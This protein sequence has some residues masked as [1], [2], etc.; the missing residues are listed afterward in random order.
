MY[1]VCVS[2]NTHSQARDPSVSADKQKA[3]NCSMRQHKAR[4]RSSHI[5]WHLHIH[6]HTTY[7]DTHTMY[8]PL[9]HTLNCAE[10][11]PFIYIQIGSYKFNKKENNTLTEQKNR[12]LVFSPNII[13]RIFPSVQFGFYLIL[14]YRLFC[15]S[16]TD[17]VYEKLLRK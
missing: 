13:G 15:Q 10:I 1:G 8:T 12:Q 7:T 16:T 9:T 17:F 11:I 4:N 14:F 6:T 3:K 2:C 5:H